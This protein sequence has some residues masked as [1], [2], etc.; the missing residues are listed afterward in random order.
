MAGWLLMLASAAQL[1]GVIVGSLGTG[2]G[3]GQPLRV[4]LVGSGIVVVPVFL[5]GVL[6]LVAGMRNDE[7][8]FG[9]MHAAPAH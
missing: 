6:F 1:L 8:L 4:H 5:V 9:A 2:A 7:P 3:D